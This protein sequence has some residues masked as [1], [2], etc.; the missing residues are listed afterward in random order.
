MKD[1]VTL[2]NSPKSSL[3]LTQKL[4]SEIMPN[5]LNGAELWLYTH[6]RRI[7]IG[8]HRIVIVCVRCSNVFV[9][10]RNVFKV[11]S[12]LLNDSGI[13]L[14]KT[15]TLKFSPFLTV[16]LSEFIFLILEKYN[17]EELIYDWQTNKKINF[18]TF[19]KTYTN[20]KEL[21]NIFVLNNKICVQKDDVFNLFSLKNQEDSDRFLE[22]LENY[23]RKNNRS[24]A[25]FVKDTSSAQRKWVYKILVEKGFDKKR[26][27][28]LKTT[29]LRR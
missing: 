7:I 19:I 28:R 20:N 10:V 12:G 1:L 11:F 25:I 15:S 17:K 16:N 13:P 22:V 23:F 8:F 6:T 29:F 21:K 5:G 3:T 4:C 18:E 27:Y 9:V 24:D 2:P 14:Y 26:L